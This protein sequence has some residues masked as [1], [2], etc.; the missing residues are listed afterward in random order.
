MEFRGPGT[1][2]QR[3]MEALLIIWNPAPEYKGAA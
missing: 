1:G 3:E 2:E